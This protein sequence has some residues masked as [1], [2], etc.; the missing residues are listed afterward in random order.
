MNGPHGLLLGVATYAMT[1]G[2]AGVA[3]ASG[4]AT[5]PPPDAAI[6]V[7]VEQIPTG[8][9]SVAAGASAGNASELAPS[10]VAKVEHKA[11]QHAQALIAVATSPG[12]G[13]PPAPTRSATPAK[14]AARAKSSKPA[15]SAPTL[16]AT[17]PVNPTDVSTNGRLIGLVAALLA[18]TLGVVLFARRERPRS[19]RSARPH[20]SG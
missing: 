18:T 14:V 13:A 8:S 6:S 5:T 2:F 19:A 3:H 4:S 7:Y 16:K 1:C 20:I 12:L 11:G 15:K 17:P 9:G 10:L